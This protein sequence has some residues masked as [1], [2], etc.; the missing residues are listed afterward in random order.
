[1]EKCHECGKEIQDGFV[2]TDDGIKTFVVCDECM[3]E[4]YD[5]EELKEKYENGESYW[6][7]FE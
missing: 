2:L 1:M 6:T 3:F 5:E 4:M 7:E